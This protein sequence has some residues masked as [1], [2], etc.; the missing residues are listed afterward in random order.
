MKVTSHQDISQ[1]AMHVKNDKKLK[2]QEGKK[3]L[4]T[5]EKFAFWR[6]VIDVVFGIK[7]G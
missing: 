6:H 1:F 3:S 7:G 4:E 5:F 2:S